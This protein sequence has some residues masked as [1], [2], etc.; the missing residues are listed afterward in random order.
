MVADIRDLLRR[1][2]D[3]VMQT[4]DAATQLFGVA[5]AMDGSVPAKVRAASLRLANDVESLAFGGG[6]MTLAEASARFESAIDDD[7]AHDIPEP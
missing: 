4:T 3:G 1:A 7:P 6:A 2:E 5:S